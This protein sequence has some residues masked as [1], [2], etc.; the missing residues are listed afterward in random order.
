VHAARLG[1][2]RSASEWITAHRKKSACAPDNI[3]AYEAVRLGQSGTKSKIIIADP[4]P[5]PTMSK[6]VLAASARTLAI[7]AT[8]I[9]NTIVW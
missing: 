7:V 2:V 8:S 9:G 4:E 5:P 6:P 1:H 3:R